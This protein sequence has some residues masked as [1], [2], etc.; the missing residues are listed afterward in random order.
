M[1]VVWFSEGKWKIK[2][3]A[4]PHLCP[5]A[6][7]SD[8]GALLAH[9]HAQPS[10]LLCFQGH[11]CFSFAHTESNVCK[12][13]W[14]LCFPVLQPVVGYDCLS[15]LIWWWCQCNDLVLVACVIYGFA[16]PSIWIS[17]LDSSSLVHCPVGALWA[18]SFILPNQWWH[19]S[20][21]SFPLCRYALPQ[22]CTVCTTSLCSGH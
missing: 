19:I 11:Y 22:N 9:V 8:A 10:P 15:P 6:G 18:R 14:A 2:L 16:S 5:G 3:F 17:L 13:C 12:H 20:G 4:V 1:S 21:W 7:S